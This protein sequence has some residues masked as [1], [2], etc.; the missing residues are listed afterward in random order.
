M[1]RS[2]T[3][4]A[5]IA[6][7]FALLEHSRN[8][9]ALGLLVLFVPLWYYLFG[10]ATQNT[11]LDFKYWA[12]GAFLHVNGENLTYITAGLNAI[13]LIV[14]FLFLASTMKGNQF[15]RRL[16][17]SGYP[18]G[19][20]LLS[21]MAA[22]LIVTVLVSLYASLVLYAFWHPGSPSNLFIIWLG[23]FCG[24]I[25]YGALGLLLGVLVTN[26]LAGFFLIIMISLVD[27]ALQNPLGNPLANQELL[28]GF[29]SFGPMQ[30]SV[31]GGF[32]TLFPTSYLLLSLV[33]FAGFAVLGLIIFWW[34]T[35]ARNVHIAPLAA[36]SGS[37]S[38]SLP[39]ITPGSSAAS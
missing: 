27:T 4:R 20:L 29:P 28:K 9:L 5:L 17:L 14:G 25:I 23:F 24:A 2:L 13:T 37:G 31:A 35:R 1:S 36:P 12:T 33:W 7:R 8:R 18:Q 22:L 38:G 30:L 26:E 10:L 15:D 19:V 16:V 6:T 11:L 39:A 21:K 34:R 32:T 3:K